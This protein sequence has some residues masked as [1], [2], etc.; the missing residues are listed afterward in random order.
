MTQY[1]TVFIEQTTQGWI[2][3]ILGDDILKG[4]EALGYKCRKGAYEDYRGEDISF[5]MWWGVTQ[6]HKEAKL[7]A[8]FITHTDDKYKEARLLQMKDDFDI[9]F[10]MSPEDAQYLV[11]LGYDTSKV[12]GI[13]LPVRN[14]YVEPIKIGIF[15]RCYP[16]KRKNEEWL[17]HFCETNPNSRLVDFV[18][19]GDGWGTFVNKLSELGCSFQWHSTSRKLPYEYMYQQLKLRD[20]DFYIYMGMDGGAM[21]SYD[22]YA[23]GVSLCVTDDGFHKGI[24]DVDYMFTTEDEFHNQLGK[25]V[26]KQLRKL[27]FFINNSV[28]NYVK[29]LAYVIENKAYPQQVKMGVFDYSVQKKR[30]ANFF[31]RGIIYGLH[32]LFSLYFHNWLNRKKLLLKEQSE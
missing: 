18:F 24:S 9:F 17:Y 27:E 10:T 26:D 25:I 22:A 5:H 23:M 29:N 8:V 32:N 28:A 4:F 13:N 6:P 19:I 20:L 21:G 2:L 16:D 1:Q 15:S 12:Y 11:E 7:N 30:Q 3:Q 31:G 14:T